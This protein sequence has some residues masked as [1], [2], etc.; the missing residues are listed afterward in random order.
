MACWSCSGSTYEE[1]QQKLVSSNCT[2]ERSCFQLNFNFSNAN[3][4]V[5][6]FSKGCLATSK[7]DDYRRG[8][9]GL[10][11]TQRAL[12]F[13]GTCFGEC[14][15]GEG[16]NQGDLLALSTTATASSPTITLTASNPTNK[17]T[18]FIIS[19]VVLFCGLILTAVNIG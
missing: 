13:N 6:L 18:A 8:N 3:E 5:I 10:C 4:S 16:C 7:C 19:L 11:Q 15:D 2:S 17:G 1:C 14:C 12:G 9:A